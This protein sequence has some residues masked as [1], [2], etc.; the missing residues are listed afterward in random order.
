VIAGA[1]KA[2]QVVTNA[3][4]GQWAP[5]PEDLVALDEITAP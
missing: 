1:S 3:E 2:D 5:N 4:A